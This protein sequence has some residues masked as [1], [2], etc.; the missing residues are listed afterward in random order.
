MIDGHYNRVKGAHPVDVAGEGDAEELFDGLVRPFRLAVGLGI[1]SAR[2]AAF[3]VEEVTE[4]APD[5]GHQA[6]VTIGSEGARKTMETDDIVEELVGEDHRGVGG[7]GLDQ[8][9]HLGC[10]V[11][12]GKDDIVSLAAGEGDPVHADGLPAAEGELDRL[13][14]ASAPSSLGFC[15]L[16]D[17]AALDELFDGRG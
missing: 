12:E 3:D 8:M 1:V 6:G 5:L 10:P 2:S 15:A 13:Q 9:Y 7:A 16:T 11:R 4:L 17:V 14:E